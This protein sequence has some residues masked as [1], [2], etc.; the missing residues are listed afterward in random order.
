MDEFVLCHFLGWVAKGMM[1]RSYTL[2]WI[3]SLFWELTELF[4][5]EILPN[6][7]ECWYTSIQHH[8]SLFFTQHV[9]ASIYDQAVSAANLSVANVCR[10]AAKLRPPPMMC[11][12]DK[13]A[14]AQVIK[15]ADSF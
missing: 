14:P 2:A 5:I 3:M 9:G 8:G 11:L 6:F 12:V 13:K 7:L 4:Y 15:K 1:L 10:N